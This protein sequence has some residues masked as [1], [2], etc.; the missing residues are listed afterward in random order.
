MEGPEAAQRIRAMGYTGIIIAL[1]GNALEE[2]VRVFLDKG[3][4]AVMTK[5]LD[6]D[7]FKRQVLHQF[8]NKTQE[9]MTPP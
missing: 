3:A 9:K 8:A 2:D 1:T 7:E 4:N 5:P 6:K